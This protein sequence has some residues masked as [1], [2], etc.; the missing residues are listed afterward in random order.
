MVKPNLPFTNIAFKKTASIKKSRLFL[1]FLGSFRC[2]GLLSD[3]ALGQIDKHGKL[4]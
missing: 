2:P 4:A 3:D 1:I